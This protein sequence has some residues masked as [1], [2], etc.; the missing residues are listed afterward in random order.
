MPCQGFLFIGSIAHYE[1]T[2]TAPEDRDRDFQSAM[3]EIASQDRTQEPCP[4]P[5]PVEWE[6]HRSFYACST[7]VNHREIT[8]LTAKK[9]LKIAVEGR[10]PPLLH[11]DPPHRR[12][13][14]YHRDL[15]T[16]KIEYSYESASIASVASL[17]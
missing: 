13:R 7:E 17:V 2:L 1:A 4:L 6:V 16:R 15:P 9:P 12:R 5:R 10:H 8:C 14:L 11:G 3:S